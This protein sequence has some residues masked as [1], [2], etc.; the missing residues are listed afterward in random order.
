[1]NDGTRM[2]PPRT[3]PPST[4]PRNAERVADG[5]RVTPL[6]DTRPSTPNLS[7]ILEAQR[8]RKPGL[9]MSAAVITAGRDGERHMRIEQFWVEVDGHLPAGFNVETLPEHALE[10]LME[11]QSYRK[12]FNGT[13]SVQT[14]LTPLAPLGT[15]GVLMAWDLAT[16]ETIEQPWTWHPRSR[17]GGLWQMIKR[18]LWTH[19]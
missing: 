13:G 11:Q 15:K 9:Q 10:V 6:S 4:K 19:D 12:T 14:G 5:D 18:L 2:P 1:M 7:A 8:R 17:G 3:A 16:G